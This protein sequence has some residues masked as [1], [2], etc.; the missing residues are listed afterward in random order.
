VGAGAFGAVWRARD[1]QLDR[2]VA[3]KLLHPGLVSSAADRERFQREARAAAQL[4][5]PGIVTVHEVTTLDG[6]PAIVS[7]FIDG[8]TLREFLEVRRLTF[9]ESAGLVAQ[10]AEALD[11][12]H[13]MGLVHRDV[14]PA[15]IM[16]DIDRGRGGG[17]GLDGP[18]T[19]RTLVLDFGLALRA[20]A[21]VTMTVDGQIVGTPA[22]MSP[23]QA[24][25]RGHQVD[26]RSDVYALGVVLYEL[27][28]GELPFRGS[29]GMLRLQVLQEEPRPPRRLNDKIPRDLET[30]CL[31]AM[32]KQPG[33]RYATARD[34]ADDLRRFLKGEPIQ[35]QPVGSA[36]RAWRWCRRN[37]AVAGLLTAVAATLV[38]GSA[39]ATYFALAARTEAGRAR[40]SEQR[41]ETEAEKAKDSEKHATEE[42]RRATESEKRLER[43]LTRAEG[44]LYAA[45]IDRAQQYWRAGHAAAAQEQLDGC[46]WD[47]RGWEHHYLHTLFQAS[48]LTLRQH[49][50]T[51]NSVCF[52]PDGRRLASASYDQ[53]VRVWDAHTGQ[54]TL[55][56][57][58]HTGSVRCVC[59]SPDGRHLASASEDQTVKVWDAQTG[60][61]V[62]T[63]RGHTAW[64]TSVCFSPDG[65]RL[66]SASQDKTVRL[67][68]AQ[69]GQGQ[70]TLKGH[71]GGVTSVCWSPDGRRLASA[72]GDFKGGEVKVWDAQTG[73][74]LRTLKGHKDLVLSVCWSPDGRRLAGALFGGTAKVWNAQTGQEL[75]TFKGHTASV[76]SVCFS[77]DG[78]RLASV[79]GDNTVKVWDAQ[80]GQE[81][82]TLRGHIDRVNSVCYS[83]DGR[84]LASASVDE[85]VKVWD[86][87][88][89][90]EVLTLPGYTG[91]VG[92]VCYSPDGRRLASTSWN[93]VTVWD[94]QTRQETLSPQGHS[95]P[96]TRVGFSPDAQRVVAA[97]QQGQVRSWDARTGQEVVPCTDPS[98]PQQ[99]QAISPDGQRVVRID[100]GRPVVEPR[101]LHTGDLFRQ[102][103]AE[104]VGAHLWHL[105]LAREARASAD[106]FAL[107]FHLEPLLL[108]SFT[109]WGAR[110]RDTFSL[111]A[112]RPPLTRAPV[113]TAGAPVPLTEAEVQRLHE[114]LSRRLDAEPKGW[115]LWAGRGW[116]RHLLGD[117]PGAA[118]DL[119]QAIALH[120]DEPGLWAVLGTVY[121]KH[122][123]PHEA[124]A[125]RRKLARWAGIDVAVWHSVEADACEQEGD[126]ATAHW[127]VNQWLAGL[128]APCPQ[129][130]A[131]RGR[132]ALEVGRETDAARDYAAA[133]RLGRTDADTLGWHARLCLTTGDQEG[134]RQARAT[135]LNQVDPQNAAGVARTVLLA[136]AAGT[137]LDPLLKG[138]TSQGT[139]A[140]TQTA[141][142]G[143]LFRL[144]RLAEAVTELQR[145]STQRPSGEAPVADLLL[146]LAQQKQGQA[147][148][149][150]RTLE[151]T[152]FLLDAEAPTRQA[153]GL[154]GGGMAGPWGATGAAGQALAAAPPR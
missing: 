86:A 97:N 76:H 107:A 65:R 6:V 92:S 9:R 116:C 30:V 22:Y 118:A 54:E 121:L 78:R 42:A 77:P 5:H 28:C 122:H 25:G 35:A 145:A 58:G 24:L 150:R 79:S 152:R 83:P 17:A 33:R 64:V 142:G 113:G 102:R 10:V 94:A 29:K 125:V 111:W 151:R 106:A 119:K 110:P 112:G 99:A 101:I 140:A 84:R 149:A 2:L 143:L 105:R 8:V 136:P 60:Q 72:S 27:L 74:E 126:W 80:T 38:L 57:K 50:S 85:T 134:F 95:D 14:K 147:A 21:E 75:L 87:Q 104:P 109:E 51:V 154:L 88:T 31:K 71:D 61:E 153:A 96:V 130:L 137:N 3:L 36:E 45:Q 146:A 63:L 139:N 55:T 98:P 20:E 100:R 148:A 59:F 23:E 37:P 11:Y 114:A 141:R 73:Q 115:P 18:S 138:L 81:L 49:T 93:T 117:L 131:R 52:S 123:R 19:P 13:A 16:I 133:V 144:G 56:I 26:R 127:H 69:T 128:P 15:N 103:L 90:Q 53:T 129:L 1:P 32:A 68:D 82:L 34:L 4:R 48:H 12:A 40:D 70:L 7:D 67:R 91:W 39:V 47:Y 44:L 89:G 62:L 120:A 41:A 46:R 132:L 135:L 124:E 43:Q 108:T 66:A